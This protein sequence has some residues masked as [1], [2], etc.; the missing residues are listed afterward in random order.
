MVLGRHGTFPGDAATRT[1]F[2]LDEVAQVAV[3]TYHVG[4]NA[5]AAATV[6]NRT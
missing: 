4:A 1:S 5:R 3:N 6:E 2:G